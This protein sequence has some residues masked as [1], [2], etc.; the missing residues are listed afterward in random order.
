MFKYAMNFVTIEMKSIF[1]IQANEEKIE[2]IHQQM[3]ESLS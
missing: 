1:D 3:R 2:F